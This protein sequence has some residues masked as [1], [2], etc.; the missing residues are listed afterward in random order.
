VSVCLFVCVCTADHTSLY[1]YLLLTVSRGWHE[2][3]V[4]FYFLRLSTAEV[5]SCTVCIY[6]YATNHVFETDIP[7]SAGYSWLQGVWKPLLTKYSSSFKSAPAKVTTVRVFPLGSWCTVTIIA[8]HQLLTPLFC[9][10]TCFAFWPF[11]NGDLYISDQVVRMN[12]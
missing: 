2:S 5:D 1:Y 4:S 12:F 9:T 10:W 11:I 7:L 6:Y 3:G 8:V